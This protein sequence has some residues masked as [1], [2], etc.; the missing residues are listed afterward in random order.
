MNTNG[1]FVKSNPLDFKYNP[2]KFEPLK[3]YT[4]GF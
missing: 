4:R 1:R 2:L 3:R